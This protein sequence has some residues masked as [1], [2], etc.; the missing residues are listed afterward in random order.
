MSTA[1]ASAGSDGAPPT[2]AVA[3]G[4]LYIITEYAANG[5]LHDYIKKQKSRLTEDLIW[6]LYIQVGPPACW[7]LLATR[8]TELPSPLCRSCW[9]S[10][11]CIQKRF[12]IATLRR[13]T[14]SSMRT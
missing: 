1:F 7:M 8:P 3:Q 13:S 6:K 9:A 4:K 10:T 2:F 5:N 12:S 14:S 11:T